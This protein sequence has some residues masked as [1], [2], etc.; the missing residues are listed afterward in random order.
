MAVD[1]TWVV[2]ESMGSKDPKE[3][4]STILNLLDD[5]AHISTSLTPK[6]G[7]K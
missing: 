5:L 7:V 3:S 4:L 2:V 1:R 6:R